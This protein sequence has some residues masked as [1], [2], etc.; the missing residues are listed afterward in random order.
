MKFSEAIKRGLK[1]LL[2]KNYGQAEKSQQIE[3]IIEKNA[4]TT[5]IASSLNVE[6]KGQLQ[7]QKT[8]A[9]SKPLQTASAIES[10]HKKQEMPNAFELHRAF[11]QQ[12]HDA[13]MREQK[14]KNAAQDD[15]DPKDLHSF[16]ERKRAKVQIDL[17][18]PQITDV[19]VGI[20]FGTS[21][22][23]SFFS[24][25][26]GV[27]HPIAFNNENSDNDFFLP[28][29]LYYDP[30]KDELAFKSH[31]GLVLIEY[32]KYGII[33]DELKNDIFKKFRQKQG[34]IHINYCEFFCSVFFLANVIKIS[35][36]YVAKKLSK[37]QQFLKFRFNMGCPIDNWNDK[38]LG[39]YGKALKLGYLLSSQASNLDKISMNSLQKFC[40][41][42][43]NDQEDCQ[44][45]AIPELYAEA[46]S[47]IHNSS[48]DEGF[49]TIFD[50]GG[51]TVDFAVIQILRNN[52]IKKVKFISQNVVPIGAEMLLRKFYPNA[53]SIEEIK[54]N[55][56]NIRKEDAIFESVD[57][58]KWQT[59]T[60]PRKRT[61]YEFRT[62]FYE[63]ICEAKKKIENDAKKSTNKLKLQK[64]L[65]LYMYGGGANYKWY[66]SIIKEH[67]STINQ[68]GIP[69]L[70]P[71]YK[72]S[73]YFRLII[74]ENL[75]QIR[76]FNPSLGDDGNVLFDTVFKPVPEE[77]VKDIEI[78][79]YGIIDT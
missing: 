18:K 24:S 45:Q 16:F 48:T 21:Y 57:L 65:P 59:L 1:V 44:L 2:N 36:E 6:K 55:R 41:E 42:H 76:D 7:K 58:G 39:V 32:F 75:A 10:T 40:K 47:F 20:D 78:A 77:L 64:T 15:L 17:S 49:Y 5:T 28:S 53:T 51:G 73:N 69:P 79:D 29:N 62:G 33:K 72:K 35:K 13:M 46:Y 38:N 3:V 25:S 37:D 74:A 12:K 19:Y 31:E 50:V 71:I 26:E 52:E 43:E 9:Y 67:N 8:Q 34:S 11:Y 66:Q 27:S 63:K 60:D 70:A 30:I 4:K 14:E 54:K 22:T 61:P 23:K 68:K 56:D